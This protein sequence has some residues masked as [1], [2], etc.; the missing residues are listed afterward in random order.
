MI[1]HWTLDLIG[2]WRNT[3]C[4]DRG[5]FSAVLGS[6]KLSHKGVELMEEVAGG[7]THPA[8]VGKG[9]EEERE[10]WRK[11]GGGGGGGGGD[12]GGEEEG[13]G[14]KTLFTATVVR[15]N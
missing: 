2:H 4:V 6:S 11:G 5:P 8:W 15:R 12:G 7:D 3:P 14:E 13:G 10:G 9:R 1:M